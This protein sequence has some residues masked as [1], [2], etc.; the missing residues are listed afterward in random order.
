MEAMNLLKE[1]DSAATA[2]NKDGVKATQFTMAI[3][4]PLRAYFTTRRAIV[5][6]GVALEVL[7]DLLWRALQTL[8]RTSARISGT[9]H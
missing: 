5:G 2:A 9:R 7:R 6:D 8:R 3:L 4:P 1:L